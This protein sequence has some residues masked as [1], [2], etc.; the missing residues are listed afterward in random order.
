MRYLRLVA[1]AGATAIVLGAGAFAFN[2]AASLFRALAPKGSIEYASELTTTLRFNEQE[3]AT[4]R[5]TECKV[6][7]LRG[8]FSQ[9]PFSIKSSGGPVHFVR[10]DGSVVFLTEINSCLWTEVE[11]GSETLRLRPMNVSEQ[12]RVANTPGSLDRPIGGN[13]WIIDSATTPRL[14]RM[15]TLADV[16]D[17]RV[18]GIELSSMTLKG[19]NKA[20]VEPVMEDIPFFARIDA[21]PAWKTA[22][23]EQYRA[24]RASTEIISLTATYKEGVTCPADQPTGPGWIVVR[25]FAC[26]GRWG[27]EISPRV[28]HSLDGINVSLAG[29][30]VGKDIVF[31]D[32]LAREGLGAQEHS[33][34]FV[35]DYFVWTPSVCIEGNCTKIALGSRS[36]GTASLYNKTTGQLVVI[37]GTRLPITELRE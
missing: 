10:P 29:K 23:P 14:G 18:P 35:K 28:T 11:P 37:V 20:L 12:I 17:G 3:V 36:G 21:M 26:D 32:A 7:D 22:T 13:V 30:S 27:G 4:T 31:V 24:R 33:A 9:R 16:A 6:T 15:V 8:A 1:A 2:M 5:R 25:S 34:D 19:A